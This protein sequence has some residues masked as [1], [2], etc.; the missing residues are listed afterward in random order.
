MTHLP[1]I[2]LREERIV[3]KKNIFAI[4]TGL[5]LLIGMLAGCST[6]K[7]SAG[8]QGGDPAASA[9]GRFVESELDLPEH[10]Q[11]VSSVAGNQN[12]EITMLGYDESEQALYLAHTTDSAKSWSETKLDPVEC[13]VSAVNGEAGT[14]AI[15]GYESESGMV[16]VSADGSQ[17]KVKL[18]IPALKQAD[19]QVDNF[20]TGAVYADGKLFAV[21]LNHVLYE[22][23]EKTGEMTV[24]SKSMEESADGLLAIG[25]RFGVVTDNDIKIADAQSGELGIK[26]EVLQKAFAKEKLG[27]NTGASN[28]VMTADAS[29]E[30]YYMNHDGL[31]YHKF[32]GSTIEQ[33]MD[34]SLASVSDGNMGFRALVKTDD[35]HFLLF[36]VDAQGKDRILQYSYDANVS[37]VPEN[38]LNVYA[39]EDSNVLQQLINAYQKKYPDV[40]VKKTIGMSGDDGVTAE[41]AIKTL[42]TQVLAGNGPDVLVLDGL[43]ADSY[44]EKGALADV[45]S[46]VADANQKEG[47]FTNI[48]DAYQTDGKIYQVPVRFYCSIAEGDSDLIAASADMGSLENYVKKLD[49]E[50]SPVC[51]PWSAESL[52]YTL[53]CA[54][55]ASWKTGEGIDTGR[56][57]QFLSTAKILYDA[58]GYSEKDRSSDDMARGTYDG[59]L[60]SL[61]IQSAMLRLSHMGQVSIGS[62]TDIS[63]VQQLYAIEDSSSGTYALAD[64]KEHRAFVPYVSLG[65]AKKAADNKYAQAWMELALSAEG[66]K[67]M[68]DGFSVNRAAFDT[69]CE[70]SSEFYIGSSYGEEGKSVSLDVKKITEKQKAELVKLL[71]SLDTP[72]WTDRV[73]EDLVLGEGKKYL[74]GKQSL[75]ETVSAI[76]KKVQL[77]DAE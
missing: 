2:V 7:D 1:D 62:L 47:L 54:D 30:L 23:D 44:I 70:D 74:Q 15:F 67:Q 8:T 56:L 57:Q 71:E 38:Q 20:I 45:S 37:A 61:G 27:S 63:S 53:Y 12:G 41:D 9:K 31:F 6:T 73:I 68:S 16:L 40:L 35:K 36:A 33:L 34:G 49:P 14:A 26:D 42:N 22:V 75:E 66:Q 43:P 29:D 58:D 19:D 65:L 5:V 11:A 55:S 21:D 28:I 69:A 60:L 17:K 64:A 50:K 39:L 10:I 25:S 4:L 59:Q 18:K 3:K 13:Y 24:F 72:S 76:T 46:Y 52:L 51:V 32:G 77:Y 48:T